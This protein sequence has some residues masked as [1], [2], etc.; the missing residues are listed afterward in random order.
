MTVITKTAI[1]LESKMK[2][3]CV[4]PTNEEQG[5]PST[6][7]TTPLYISLSMT[8]APSLLWRLLAVP[9]NNLIIINSNN[10]LL[11]SLRL[12]F[13][14]YKASIAT[15]KQ[16]LQ[17]SSSSSQAIETHQTLCTLLKISRK[18]WWMQGIKR[19][20]SF[21]KKLRRS[22][23]WELEPCNMEMMMIVTGAINKI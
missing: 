18:N 23:H 10:M 1:S 12:A 5:S 7:T 6:H 15:R 22:F 11:I 20:S 9:S 16:Q 19:V 4:L 13:T 17:E 21:Q 3:T 14:S 2:W 8:T